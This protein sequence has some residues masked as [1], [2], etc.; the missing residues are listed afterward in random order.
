MSQNDLRA[1]LLGKPFLPFR[2]HLSDGTTYDIR[3]PDLAQPTQATLLL[4]IP[5]A[6]PSSS[7]WQRPQ[8]IS[9]RHIVRV[10]PLPLFPSS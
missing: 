10:E 8:V 7:L 6:D 4:L 1:L 5:G 9:L 3:H 2:L